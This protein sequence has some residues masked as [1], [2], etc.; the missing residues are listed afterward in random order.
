MV[1]VE[2]V[3]VGEHEHRGQ[4]VDPAREEPQHVERGLVGPVHVL[5]DEHG[6]PRRR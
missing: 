4:V 2:L 5:H 6:A 1:A 3:A